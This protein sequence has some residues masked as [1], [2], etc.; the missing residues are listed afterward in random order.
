MWCLTYTRC[1]SSIN[2]FFLGIHKVNFYRTHTFSKITLTVWTNS[3]QIHLKLLS[4]VPEQLLSDKGNFLPQ[5]RAKEALKLEFLYFTPYACQTQNSLWGANWW[6]KKMKNKNV[7][8]QQ[9]VLAAR[10][11]GSFQSKNGC[12]LNFYCLNSFLKQRAK[13]KLMIKM[14]NGKFSE[15]SKEVTRDHMLPKNRAFSKC[16]RRTNVLICILLAIMSRWKNTSH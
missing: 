14:C 12:S 7:K 9:W 5:N 15:Q 11:R 10:R 3:V 8:M 4:L 16:W 1:S 13:K 2:F 6:R